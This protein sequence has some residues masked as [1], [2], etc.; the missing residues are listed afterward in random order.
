MN[1][2]EVLTGSLMLSEQWAGRSKWC[3]QPGLCSHSCSL[4]RVRRHCRPCLAAALTLPSHVDAARTA[5]TAAGSTAVARSPAP[6]CAER[7]GLLRTI[8]ASRCRTTS[9]GQ[10]LPAHRSINTRC[11]GFLLR[12]LEL[13]R[14]ASVYLRQA[15]DA[16]TL[17]DLA[18]M[19]VLFHNTVY[20][21]TELDGDHHLCFVMLEAVPCEAVQGRCSVAAESCRCHMPW[22]PP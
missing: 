3:I 22:Q 16:R 10:T 18:Q 15:S 11:T 9:T 8:G 13:V 12:R 5:A 2:T 19:Q 4:R 1:S 6:L 20:A 14:A 7:R 21:L 17:I